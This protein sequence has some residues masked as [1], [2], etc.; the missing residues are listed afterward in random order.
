MIP[1]ILSNHKH[2]RAACYGIL[3]SYR[4][5]HWVLY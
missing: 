2:N 4:Q 5:T 1:I 3:P